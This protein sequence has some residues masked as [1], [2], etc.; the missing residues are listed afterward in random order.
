[1]F[2]IVTDS[3][4][5]LP[6]DIIRKFRITIVPQYIMIGDK[7]FRDRIDISSDYLYSIMA[8]QNVVPKTSQPTPVDYISAYEML[9]HFESILCLTPPKNLSGA[10]N[11]AILASQ[12]V[13]TPVYVMDTNTISMGLGFI[14]LKSCMLRDSDYKVIPAID[15]LKQNILKIGLLF[16]VRSL[17]YLYNSGRVDAIGTLIGNALQVK[18]II[19]I[20][21]G[22]P[23]IKTRVRTY[24]RALN[25]FLEHLHEVNRV[26]VFRS[27]AVIHAGAF[28]EAQRL[29]QHLDAT[30]DIHNSY[31]H[32]VSPTIGSHVGP[33]AIG[34]AYEIE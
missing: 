11:S 27:V 31:I 10:Y 21:N 18:P 5:D 15:I 17:D 19:F 13:S 16:T 20:E 28:G 33:G 2:A 34:I 7:I 26:G 25:Y 6:E 32:T 1:M 9:A 14:V 30:F 3:T 22:T 23:V 29:L 24:Q 4:C 8:H 12:S